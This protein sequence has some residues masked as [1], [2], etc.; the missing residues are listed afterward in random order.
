MEADA[1][2]LKSLMNETIETDTGTEKKPGVVHAVT[3]SARMVAGATLMVGGGG[4]IHQALK[5]KKSG[6]LGKTFNVAVG[7]GTLI[8][9]AKMFNKGDVALTERF[10]QPTEADG[11]HLKT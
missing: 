6:K 8:S 10:N 3:N 5:R 4:I 9:G 11:Y 7:A 1:G 2:H